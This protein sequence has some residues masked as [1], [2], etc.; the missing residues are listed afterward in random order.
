M[1]TA[2]A[3][4]RILSH[5]KKS[6]TYKLALLRA[7][8]DIVIEQP[9]QEPRNGFHLIPVVEI[10]RRFLAYYW[11]PALL[12]VPQGPG[13]KGSEPRGKGPR[14]PRLLRELRDQGFMAARLDLAQEDMGS[15]VAE[16]L[17]EIPELP[18]A[19]LDTLLELRGTILDQP[20]RYLPNLGSRRAEVLSVVTIPRADGTG[21]PAW[22]DD[23]E[24]HRKAAPG[25][26]E[27]RA[28][29]WLDLLSRERTFV[30]L[31]SRAYEEI[32]DLRFWLRDAVLVR[33]LKECQ[34]FAGQEQPISI[35][36]L[37]LK[38]PGRDQEVVE[39]LKAIYWQAGL[40]SCLYSGRELGRSQ[41]L[42]HVLPFSRFP[43]NLFW[44]LVPAQPA[45]N[46]QK[47]DRVPALTEPFA[48]RYREFIS[49]CLAI[50]T[51]LLRRQLQVTW[52]RYFQ[53][54]EPPALPQRQLADQL[55]EM[56]RLSHDRLD[57]AGVETWEPP[58]EVLA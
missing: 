58:A 23:Y 50:G 56:V 11:K 5:G 37:Q 46:L 29:S 42:D 45:L 14:I 55:F 44:N 52:R 1:N 17:V 40:R 9:A 39:E 28:S 36:V 35:D 20:L 57:R 4:E 8:V 47:S 18:P 38:I 26:R 53:E 48:G 41:H 12:Q 30:V 25:K 6:S 13:S 16:W 24:E 2:A 33:W 27:L 3:I 43:V 51:P 49:S 21:A 22:T 15:S 34:R 31:S 7:V 54:P 19:L 32:A 10:A